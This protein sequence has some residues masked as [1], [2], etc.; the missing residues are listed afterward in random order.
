MSEYGG[1]ELEEFLSAYP[2][3]VRDLALR[4][5]SLVLEAFP[6]AVEIVDAPSNLI[7]YGFGT[8][9]A[10]LVCGIMPYRR[11]VNLIFAQGASLP[12]PQGLLEGTGKRARHVKIQSVAPL[13]DPGLLAL[14]QA[15]VGAGQR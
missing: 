14:I 15:A 10:D 13:A 2:V 7:A 4:V 1:R 6:N 5:R 11:H 9:Y 3:E 12:D 8:K